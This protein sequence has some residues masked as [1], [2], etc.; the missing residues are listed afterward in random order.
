MWKHSLLRGHPRLRRIHLWVFLRGYQR[1]KVII[2]HS[3]PF[4][5]P[6]FGLSMPK[7]SKTYAQGVT[8]AGLVYGKTHG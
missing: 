1:G 7:L 6:Y 8:V 5:T 3:H 2:A 4:P